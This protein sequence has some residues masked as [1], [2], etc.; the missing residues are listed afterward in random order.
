MTNESWIRKEIVMFLN[1]LNWEQIMI[2]IILTQSKLPRTG[3][4]FTKK[5]PKGGGTKL[6]IT[7]K[8]FLDRA[9]QHYFKPLIKSHSQWMM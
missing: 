7:D 8:A 2:T 3:N 6:S 5:D 9:N 1:R 4:I